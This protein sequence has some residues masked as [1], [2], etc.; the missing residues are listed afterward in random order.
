MVLYIILDYIDIPIHLEPALEEDE[1][2][3][4]EDEDKKIR[5]I[6][7]NHLEAMKM[8][9]MDKKMKAYDSFVHKYLDL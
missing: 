1:K 4:D 5:R 7:M 8:R 2:E 9:R 6:R 3:I